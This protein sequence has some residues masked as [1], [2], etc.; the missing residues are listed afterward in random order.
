[1][2]DCAVG[3]LADQ[4]IAFIATELLEP[5]EDIDAA[6]DLLLSGMVD[7]LGVIQIVEFIEETAGIEIDPV[8]VVL[9]NFQTVDAMTAFVS[10]SRR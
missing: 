6:T 3:Q 8:D 4:I 7:S 9:E 1:M 5:D 2:T 10:G